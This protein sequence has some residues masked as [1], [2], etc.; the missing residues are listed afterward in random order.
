MGM[1]VI[2]EKETIGVEERKRIA[3]ELSVV[4]SP[5]K[6]E[7]EQLEVESWITKI[8][9][10]FARIPKGQPGA[11]D[12]TVIV[13]QPQSNQPPITLPINSSQMAKGKKAKVQLSVRW[14]VEWAVRQIKMMTRIGRKVELSEIP[15]IEPKKRQ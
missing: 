11:Q 12:D 10:K 7:E 3:E 15:E 14:L 2:K 13:N 4:A 9:K 6:I 8:E 1:A 5:R